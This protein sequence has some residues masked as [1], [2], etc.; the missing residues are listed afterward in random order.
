MK[1]IMGIAALAMLAGCG[2]PNSDFEQGP[3]VLQCD[4]E[5][6]SAVMG[7][8]STKKDRR[9]FKIDAKAK[10]LQVFNGKEFVAWGDG[11]P[12]IGPDQISFESKDVGEGIYAVRSIVI[13]R[14]SGEISDSLNISM[15]GAS[16]FEGECKP[17]SAPER[18]ANKF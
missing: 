15:G 18:V 7:S 14:G 9:H 12:E 6:T 17:V 5:T 10:T 13:H 8:A 16:R 11:K 4:G 2:S 1:Y 3:V